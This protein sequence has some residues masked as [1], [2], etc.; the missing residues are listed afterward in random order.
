M[1]LDPVKPGLL[2]SATG[3]DEVADRLS[4]VLLGHGP[5]RHLI[6]GFIDG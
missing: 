3:P 2:G 4:D 1:K 6:D 5:G